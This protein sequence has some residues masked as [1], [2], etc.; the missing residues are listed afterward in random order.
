[1]QG[2]A[3]LQKGVLSFEE[4]ILAGDNLVSKFWDWSWEEG[5]P[6]GKKP[7]SPAYN[8][9]LVCRNVPC[10]KRV[11]PVK[12]ECDAARAEADLFDSGPDPDIRTY[13]IGITYDNCY[14]TPRVWLMGFDVEGNILEPQLMFED[15][16]QD[17]TQISVTVEYHP[18]M[19]P[20]A[21]VHP[22]S[23]AAE[24]KK[25]IDVLMSRGIEPQVDMYLLI[26][27]TS[28]VASVTPTIEYDCDLD[29]WAEQAAK[30]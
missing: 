8:Q 9:Y 16:S 3:F 14:K 13:D 7:Y 2:S 4:F 15:I 6:E 22:C 5:D 11:V 28:I 10:L 12:E 17:N 29:I 24:M 25:F 20:C 23:H 26:F 21:T 30:P 1:M 19:G 18:R 27:L